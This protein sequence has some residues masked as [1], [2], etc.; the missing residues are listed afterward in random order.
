M[1]MF[2]GFFLTGLKRALNC[3]NTALCLTQVRGRKLA[4]PPPFD[5]S[6]FRDA[7]LLRSHPGVSAPFFLHKNPR[8]RG[9]E[10]LLEE[11]RDFREGTYILHPPHHP[12]RRKRWKTNGEKMEKCL[13]PVFSRFTQSFS[14][15]IRDINGEKNN[16]GYW[17]SFS[18]LVFHGLPPLEHH[19][20]SFKTLLG[21]R[22]ERYIY[23]FFFSAWGRRRGVRATRKGGG[24]F[25]LKIQKGGRRSPRSRVFGEGVK[26]ARS[27]SKWLQTTSKRTQKWGPK[28]LLGHLWVA[29]GSVCQ[30]HFWV[31]FG[32]LQYYLCVS[33]R[34]PEYSSN[35]KSFTLWLFFGGG[36][37]VLAFPFFLPFSSRVY[38]VITHAFGHL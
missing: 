18:R 16:S 8:L 37:G 4:V 20:P 9:P 7:K 23:I 10:P 36:G 32:S 38:S 26:S 25:L 33:R 21:G 13:V 35:L 27:G 12:R 11:S 15:F 6:D 30:G 1:F 24:R 17:W 31:N 29:L 19:S 5:Y 22:F 28:S 14:R 34:R 2:I 3:R